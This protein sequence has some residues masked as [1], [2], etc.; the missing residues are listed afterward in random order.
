[1]I[2]SRTNIGTNHLLEILSSREIWMFNEIMNEEE[3]IPYSVDLAVLLEY[4]IEKHLIDVV[5]IETKGQ[6]VF[7]RG[8]RLNKKLS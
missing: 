5:N 4:L 8:Y 7:H 3:L 2:H 1:M 6:G